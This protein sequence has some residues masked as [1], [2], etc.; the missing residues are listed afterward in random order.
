MTEHQEELLNQYLQTRA[1]KIKVIFTDRAT[2]KK[3]AKRMSQEKRNGRI[4][5]Y[6]CKYCPNYH[7]GHNKFAPTKKDLARANAV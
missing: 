3:E 1:C 4:R 7:I 2:A 6:K 5:A